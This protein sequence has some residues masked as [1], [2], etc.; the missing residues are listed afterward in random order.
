M[1]SSDKNRI[2]EKLDADIQ[3]RSG[4]LG[5]LDLFVVVRRIVGKR[6]Q[7]WATFEWG[8][9]WDYPYDVIAA[10]EVA[11]RVNHGGARQWHQ[12][13]TAHAASATNGSIVVAC[14]GNASWISQDFADAVLAIVLGELDSQ[15][16]D[17]N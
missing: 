4:N 8:E 11:Y 7:P 6:Q 10:N 1:P 15:S 13:V 17:A 12:P 9:S 2:I 14:A 5:Y 3:E 16:P